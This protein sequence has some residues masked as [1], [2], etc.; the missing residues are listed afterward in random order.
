MAD[1]VDVIEPVAKFTSKL[2]EKPGVGEIFNVG[3]EHWFPAAGVVYDLIWIQWCVPYLDDDS[4]VQ[5]LQRCK[6]VLNPDGGVIVLKENLS[7][8]GAD[9]HDEREGSVTRYVPSP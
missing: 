5:F 1:Q 3:L 8:W 4:L 2:A 9:K 6:A 7:P